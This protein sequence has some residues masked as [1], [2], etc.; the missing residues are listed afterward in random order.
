M[1]SDQVKQTMRDERD[2][3]KY[4]EQGQGKKNYEGLQEQGKKQDYEQD[5][6]NEKEK[7]ELQKLNDVSPEETNNHLT[8]SKKDSA[9]I[10]D[11][12]EK[13]Y[14]LALYKASLIENEVVISSIS[15]YTEFVTATTVDCDDEADLIN[16]SDS[17]LESDQGLHE[18]EIL[19]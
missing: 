18:A 17:D 12:A 16:F 1:E 19:M 9:R 15:D 8:D 13:D 4:K 7:D 6:E 11:G 2:S 5:E 14:P 3:M 10:S